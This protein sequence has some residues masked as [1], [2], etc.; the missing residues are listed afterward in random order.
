MTISTDISGHSIHDKNLGQDKSLKW[1][2]SGK[3]KN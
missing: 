2:K 1:E 3:A